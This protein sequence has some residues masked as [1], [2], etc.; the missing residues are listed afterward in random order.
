MS[1]V[2]GS[3]VT[4]NSRLWLTVTVA[5][6]DGNSRLWLTVLLP[7]AHTLYNASTDSL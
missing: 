6:A 7:S 1:E 2:G 5:V 3:R 4:V